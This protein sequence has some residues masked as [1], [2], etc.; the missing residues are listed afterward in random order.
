M[1]EQPERHKYTHTYLIHTSHLSLPP[2]LSL[3]L[4]P[5]YPDT[6]KLIII[7]PGPD[8]INAEDRHTRKKTKLKK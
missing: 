3:C 5:P 6:G 8:N 2:S 4:T 7:A 1:D